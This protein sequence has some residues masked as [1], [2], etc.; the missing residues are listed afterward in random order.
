[1]KESSTLLEIKNVFF[2][3]GSQPILKNISFSIKEQEFVGIIGP[4]GGGKTTLLR[5]IMGF[6]KPNQGE[7]VLSKQLLD[8]RRSIAYVPQS[9]IYDKE[10]P[11]SVME[12]VLQGRL[13]HLPW[14]GKFSSKDVTKAEEAL[15]LVNLLEF[16]NKSF[17]QLSGGQAQ[18][19]L[20]ARALVSDP[21]ILLLD[22][23][24]ASVDMQAEAEIYQLLHKLKNSM[25]I[26]MVTHDLK[27]AIEQVDRVLCV[28]GDLFSLQPEEVCEHFALGLYHTPLIQVKK[29]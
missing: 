23:P 15:S 24:T 14:Y 1:M 22:E 11:I 3:Y 28:Q 8:K 4:N 5:L 6:L 27:V 29:S 12:V 13:S 17:G 21:L 20:I 19:T 25:S 18:R 16:K 26:L 7:I 2:S 9:L 10:F